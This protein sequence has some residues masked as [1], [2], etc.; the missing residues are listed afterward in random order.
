MSKTLED[1]ISASVA[2]YPQPCGCLGVKVELIIEGEP[3]YRGGAIAYSRD[4]SYER[5]VEPILEQNTLVQYGA[6]LSKP[7]DY[8]TLQLL[9]EGKPPTCEHTR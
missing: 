7:K 8:A 4:G 2:T 1:R 5:V 3:Q 6:L 9:T